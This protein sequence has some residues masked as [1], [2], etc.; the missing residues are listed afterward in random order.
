[1]KK[2]SYFKLIV[3]L[4]TFAVVNNVFACD[5]DC[6]KCHPTLLKHGKLDSN[7]KILQSCVKCHKL[8]NNDLLRMGSACGEDCWE[9]H[10]IKKV[11]TVPIREHLALN[12]CIACHKKLKENKYSNSYKSVLQDFS[13]EK[14]K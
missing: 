8:K 1:M 3:F 7:H 4:L 9:C 5:G 14:S 12:K 13:I 11:M 6:M 2:Y 10:S